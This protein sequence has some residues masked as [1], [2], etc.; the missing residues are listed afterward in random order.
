MLLLILTNLMYAFEDEIKHPFIFCI[1]GSS[2]L[3]RTSGGCRNIVSSFM[4]FISRLMHLLIL[5]EK[6]FMITIDFVE[7]T[8]E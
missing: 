7:M 3:I 8:N 1:T 5:E 4:F 2:T 6:K